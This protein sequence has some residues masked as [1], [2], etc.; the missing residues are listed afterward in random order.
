M[1]VVRDLVSRAE[2]T[3]LDRVWVLKTLGKTCSLLF[4]C[5]T[6][7]VYEANEDSADCVQMGYQQISKFKTMLRKSVEA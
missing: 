3:F 1:R 6:V 5:W 2:D 7:C 4:G